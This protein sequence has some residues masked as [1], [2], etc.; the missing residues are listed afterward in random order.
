MSFDLPLNIFNN[1][2]DYNEY[3]YKHYDIDINIYDER[4]IDNTYNIEYID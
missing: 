2:D 1:N 4:F 3:L